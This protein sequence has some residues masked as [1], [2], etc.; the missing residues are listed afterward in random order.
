MSLLQ[1][2]GLHRGLYKSCLGADTVGDIHQGQWESSKKARRSSIDFV[3]QHDAKRQP[4]PVCNEGKR[5]ATTG[6]RRIAGTN[7]NG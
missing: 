5:R 2:E 3:L 1:S 4:S 6:K 7:K